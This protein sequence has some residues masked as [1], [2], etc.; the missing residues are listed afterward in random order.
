MRTR[1]NHH[2]ATIILRSRSASCPQAAERLG[3]CEAALKRICR[4]NQIRKWPYRQLQSIH[5]RMT[6]LED[7]ENSRPSNNTTPRSRDNHFSQ[8]TPDEA[9]GLGKNRNLNEQRSSFLLPHEMQHDIAPS[10]E[11]S[12]SALPKREKLALL[13]EERQRVISLAHLTS[14]AR[15]LK[16]DTTTQDATSSHGVSDAT[17]TFEELLSW[18][19]PVYD[20]LQVGS[21]INN[22]MQGCQASFRKDS[23][24]LLLAN[25][26]S[27]EEKIRELHARRLTVRRPGENWQRHG[28]KALAS[29]FTIANHTY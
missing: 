16:S 14:K 7:Q 4:R 9:K 29:R 28:V 26:C 22:N 27:N 18:S 5:R 6:D 10:Y 11:T 12:D 21:P 24:L 17:L 3:I 2:R 8:H 13:E 25:V 20:S 15:R 1:C 19:V 23:A